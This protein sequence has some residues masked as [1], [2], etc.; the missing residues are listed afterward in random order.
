M[1]NILM[2][3]TFVSRYSLLLNRQN[4]EWNKSKFSEQFKASTNAIEFI[5]LWQ[6]LTTFNSTGRKAI[7]KEILA[8]PV[9][10]LTTSTPNQTCPTS[11]TSAT[12]KRSLFTSID[13]SDLQSP[14]PK[15]AAA[16]NSG[17]N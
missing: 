12:A 6:Q 4:F 14:A 3:I 16:T 5:S 7:P 2:Q 10:S 13:S 9:N 17:S 8:L 11:S 1:Y 15:R